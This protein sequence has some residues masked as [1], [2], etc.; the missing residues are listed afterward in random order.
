MLFKKYDKDYEGGRCPMGFEYIEA[1]CQGN[2]WINGYCRKL[3]KHRF[4]G[5]HDQK[6]EKLKEQKKQESLELARKAYESREITD[7]RDSISDPEKL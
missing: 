1:D 5:N 4:G 2:Q 6:Q 3:P 7:S